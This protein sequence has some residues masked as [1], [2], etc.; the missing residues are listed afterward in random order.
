MS[1]YS[2][3]SWLKSKFLVENSSSTYE[4]GCAMIYYDF[5]ELFEIQKMISPDDI[6]TES[7]DDTYGLEDKPH[8]TLLYGFHNTVSP[9]E[10][11]DVINTFTFPK[12]KL[13]NV[14]CF[15]SDKYDVLKFDVDCPMLHSVNSKLKNFPHTSSFPNYHP[16]STIGYIKKGL[17][18]K[19]VDQFK[20]LSYEVHPKSIVYSKPD[21]NKEILTL[22]T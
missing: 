11:L 10:V 8:T 2:F 20:D 22:N 19:Y 12:L 5:P 6:Y 14:S 13:F 4:Y 15:N 1:I 21:G 9:N 7:G 18:K 3:S 16:H 17:G